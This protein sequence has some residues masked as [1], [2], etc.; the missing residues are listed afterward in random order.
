MS[1]FTH[2]SGQH[3]LIGDANLYFEVAGN[4]AGKPLVLLHG[5][6]GNLADFNAILDR[7][8][9]Q[10]RFIGIDFRG[11]GK[12]TL[13]SAPLTYQQYQA[14]VERILDHLGIHSCALLGFSDG[15]IVAYRIATQTAARV[16]TLVTVGA[17]WRLEADGPVFGMLS[18]LT[19]DMWV[20]M[21]PDSVEY[22]EAVNPMPNFG[23]LVQAVVALWT[24]KTATG[25]PNAEINKITSP[26]LIVRGDGDHL[27]SLNEAAELREKI[28]GAN[29]FN[30]PFSGHEVHKD[31]PEMFLAAVNEFLV[32]P[33]KLQH[34]A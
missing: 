3:L 27:L 7:L 25:Y 6:L 33:R 9:E 14:D 34:E 10:F 2:S 23:A 22:Y 31:A 12:S 5:G 1:R 24:D 18:G 8:P 16:E 4:P 19:A 28:E 17:Q 11:H 20:E 13:G 15:G 32:Q 26:S 21:F 30:V 29:F